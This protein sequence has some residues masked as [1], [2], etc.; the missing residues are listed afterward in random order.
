MIEWIRAFTPVAAVLITLVGGWLVGQRVSDR[1]ERTK[2]QRELDLASLA[3]LYRAYG[4]FYAIW[5]TWNAHCSK[6]GA[7]PSAPADLPWVLLGRATAAEGTIE[8]LLVK[9]TTER[10]LTDSQVDA[11][12]ALRQSYRVLRSAIRHGRQLNWGYSAHPQYTALKGL[13]TYVA[14][15]L[16][17]SPGSH[18]EAG[19]AARQFARTTAN[20]YEQRWPQVAAEIGVFFPDGA[21]DANRSPLPHRYGRPGPLS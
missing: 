3:D 10:I 4:E 17:E 7:D 6:E 19:L 16:A 9:V 13:Q 5:K 11:L 2:K 18:P 8:A 12:A 15:L 21:A 1:W 20:S 14:R